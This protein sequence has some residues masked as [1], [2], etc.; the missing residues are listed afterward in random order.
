M[1]SVDFVAVCCAHAWP[2]RLL[3]S[4]DERDPQIDLVVLAELI[5]RGLYVAALP[6]IEDPRRC[7]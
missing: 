3:K 1:L 5:D 6:G 7:R 2:P 4:G